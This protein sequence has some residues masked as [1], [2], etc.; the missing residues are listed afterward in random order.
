MQNMSLEQIT[1]AVGG[2]YYG[3]RTLKHLN[4]SG[5][6]IDSRKIKTD[7]LFVPIK[8]TRVDGHDFIRE[9]MNEGALCTLTERPIEGISFPYI[10]VD[11]CEQALKSL[12]KYYRST[13]NVKVIGITGSV[14]K[15]STKEMV[16]T[17]LEQKYNVLKT[18]GNF[19]NEIGLPLTVFNIR[20]EH[21]IAILEMG[22][23]EFGEMHRLAEIAQ[24][25]L[26][27][28]TNIGMAHMENLGSREG[29]LRAKTEMFDHLKPDAHV[30]LNGDD[31]MLSTISDVNGRR[32]SFFGLSKTCNIYASDLCDLGLNGTECRI[33]L[34]SGELAVTVPVPGQHMVYNAL[35][36]AYTG[37]LLGLDPLQIK[38]GIESFTPV[39]GRNNIIK[40]SQLT[41]I[42]DCYNANPISMKASLDILGNDTHRKVAVVGDMFELGT[43]EKELHEEVGRYAAKKGIDVIYCI[44]TLAEEIYHGAKSAA[45]EHTAILHFSTKA[46]FLEQISKLFQKDDTILVKA[47]NG[48]KFTEIVSALKE[49]NC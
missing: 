40:T 34:P 5:V 27:I 21:E 48:M 18:S 49:W 36:G 16:A 35:A 20:P 23:S 33:H 7:F 38:T 31:D 9:V 25:D 14:G 24:P 3:D 28:I 30:V 45:A 32:P 19:N 10:L 22:I 11:S 2:T 37:L 41:I 29:I 4:I 42:D 1:S 6:A 44:G 43:E 26:G 17:V 13:L 39:A 12:A 15:T 8:G 46:D 47:S